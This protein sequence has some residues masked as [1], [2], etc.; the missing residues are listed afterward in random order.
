MD[1]K[2][3]NLK[4]VE[5]KTKIID[6]I[7]A[8]KIPVSIVSLVL[9]NILNEVRGHEKNIVETEL[10]EFNKSNQNEVNEGGN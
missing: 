3:P 4:I 7:N 1:N 9:E 10:E 8:S 2:G 6:E 5:F